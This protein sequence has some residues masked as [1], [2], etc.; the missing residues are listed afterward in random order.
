MAG[1]EAKFF[2]KVQNSQE[3]KHVLVIGA[4]PG[5]L[6]AAITAGQKGHQ[7]ILVDQ[8]DAIGGMLKTLRKAPMRH[9]LAE[10]MIDNYSRQLAESHVDVQLGRKITAKDVLEINP[11]VIICA[12]GSR[13]Y[14]PHS[15]IYRSP[16]IILVDNLFHKNKDQVG[17]NAIVFD[18]AGDWAGIESALYLAENGTGNTYYS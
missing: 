15:V 1:K 2:D 9:E 3:K 6:Q 7:V 4:G 18:F 13:P 17:K 5:G 14:V 11:D 12:V 10:S 16:R 8:S